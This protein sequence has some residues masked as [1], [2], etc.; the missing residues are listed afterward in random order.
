M[1]R[2]AGILIAL[3]IV[4]YVAAIFIPFAPDEQRP[5]TRLAGELV[6]A[7]EVDWSFMTE[8][9]KIWVETKTWYFIPHSVTTVS[10]VTDGE[11]YVPC[12]YCDSKRWPKNV[13]RDPDVRLK[14]GDKLYERRAVRI[15][16]PGEARPLLHA[17]GLHDMDGIAVFR[18][19]PR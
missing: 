15:T 12:G 4:A 3:L 13:D 18:T 2:V 5:G 1:Q 19:D 7:A 16:D 10:W 9:T 6:D 17:S 11:L 14:I 8:Q